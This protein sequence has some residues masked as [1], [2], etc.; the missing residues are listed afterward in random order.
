MTIY[1]NSPT[2]VRTRGFELEA[3]YDA[4]FVY[5]RLSYSREHTSQPTSF[6]SGMFAAGNV[7]E[8]PDEYYTL[9]LGDRWLERKLE[10]GALFKRD[11]ANRRL[12]PD[13]LQ[14]DNTGAYLKEEQK[15]NPV[16]IDLYASYR[17]NKQWLIRAGVRNLANRSYSS[18]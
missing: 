3:D 10:V 1:T 9:D 15:A 5:A 6:A 2:P 14:D 7:S 11:G 12:S 8:L 16:I 13:Q 17:V 18:R 4:G